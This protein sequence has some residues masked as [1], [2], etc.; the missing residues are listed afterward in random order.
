MAMTK[1]RKAIWDK[2]G[3]RCWYCGTQLQEKGW[4]EDHFEPVLRMSMYAGNGK[5]IPTGEMQKP[6]NE[7]EDNK[8]P[9]CAPCNLFKATMGIEE[10]R[11]EIEKQADRA[12]K[13]SVNFRTAERFGIVSVESAPVVFWFETMAANG[14]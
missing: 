10:F 7:N 1:R 6:N 11:A 13:Y 9:A 4:H 3:G 14:G 2:S 5:F 8:V 12:R